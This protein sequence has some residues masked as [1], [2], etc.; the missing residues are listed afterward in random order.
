[1]TISSTAKRRVGATGTAD[2]GTSHAVSVPQAQLG[3]D[4][5]AVSEWWEQA[6]CAG[7]DPTWWSEQRPMWPAA[8]ALCLSCPVRQSCL[9]EAVAY[10]DNGVIRGGMLLIDS[11][12]RGHTATPLICDHCRRRPVR[13]SERGR[14]TRYCGSACRAAASRA[15]ADQSERVAAA[16]RRNPRRSAVA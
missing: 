4:V 16:H 2:A 13:V 9:A 12:K 15:R 10:R 3:H 5:V 6:A 7:R 8:V 1:M 11:P 14:A